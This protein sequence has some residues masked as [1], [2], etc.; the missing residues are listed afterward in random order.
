MFPSLSSLAGPLASSEGRAGEQSMTTW[1]NMN[2][3]V[4]PSFFPALVTKIS[5]YGV[6]IAR[7]SSQYKNLPLDWASL[8]PQAARALSPHCPRHR[9]QRNFVFPVVSLPLQFLSD[10]PAAGLE[11]RE[12]GGTSFR[13]CVKGSHYSL[14]YGHLNHPSLCLPPFLVSFPCS[15]FFLPFVLPPFLPH[16]ASFPRL[17]LLAPFKFFLCHSLFP[18]ALSASL[19]SVSFFPPCP[20]LLPFHPIFLLLPFPACFPLFPFFPSFFS[21]FFPLLLSYSF[22]PLSSSSS[23]PSL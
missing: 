5:V 21:S 11:P 17:P 16:H 3:E 23:S 9:R 6:A 22:P 13:G 14:F 1:A 10:S 7:P 12:A 20:F 8:W 4:M 19:C 18:L 2:G 15:S